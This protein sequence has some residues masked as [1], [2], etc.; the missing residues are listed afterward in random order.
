M[1]LVLDIDKDSYDTPNVS[2]IV[3]HQY[4]YITNY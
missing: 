4:L 1:L 2:E 3:T